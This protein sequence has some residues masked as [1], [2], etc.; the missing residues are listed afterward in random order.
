MAYEKIDGDKYRRVFVVGDLHGCHDLFMAKLEDA[1]FESSLDLVVSTGD[2][3]DRGADSL[4]CLDLIN[5]KWFKC[6]RGNHEQMMI[7]SLACNMDA[8]HWIY[9]GGGWFFNLDYDKQVLARCLNE[10]ASK[11]PYIIEINRGGKKIVV[12]HAD[13]PS[14]DYAFGKLIDLSDVIWSRDR[15]SDASDLDDESFMS[16]SGADHFYFGHSPV[17]NV[18][19]VGNISYI[20]TGAVFDGGKLTLI[21]L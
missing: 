15:W 2:L 14:D 5:R 1:G 21:K 7:D 4:G 12:A 20:D 18:L 13:Y 9:N 10:M 17:N 6:V 3:I 19:N 11:L 8:S 16:I